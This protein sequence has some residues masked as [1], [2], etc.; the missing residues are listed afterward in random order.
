MIKSEKK[1]I[2]T[3]KWKKM[4]LGKNFEDLKIFFCN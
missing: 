1:I 4:N 3:K 2:F